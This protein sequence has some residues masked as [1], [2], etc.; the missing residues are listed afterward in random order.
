[1]AK[2]YVQSGTMR[3]RVQ[4]ESAQKAA[5]W[6]VHQVMQQVLPVDETAEKAP[7]IHSQPTQRDVAV[8]SGRVS[9]SQIGFDREDAQT[10]PTLEVV[11]Q[12]NQMVTTLDR[13][14]RMLHRAA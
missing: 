8:L 14:E 1:M 2:F 12:W 5:V 4:A 7:Q 6:A 13:L 11:T 10:L 9:V 3:S